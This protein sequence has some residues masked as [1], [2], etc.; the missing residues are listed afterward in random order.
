[1]IV[2]LTV[3]NL[4]EY[5]FLLFCQLL[6]RRDS[7]ASRDLMNDSIQ[8]FVAEL[9]FAILCAYVTFIAVKHFESKCALIYTLSALAAGPP[10]ALFMVF[11]TAG[12]VSPPVNYV[13]VPLLGFLTP[14]FTAIL[15]SHAKQGR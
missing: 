13:I 2:G 15:L 6:G 12:F 7:T 3:L 9:F 11:V 4:F 8:V 5:G 1:M 14:F 10:L